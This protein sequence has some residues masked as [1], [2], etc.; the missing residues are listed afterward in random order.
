MLIT[1]TFAGTF[2]IC[3]M[4]KKIIRLIYRFIKFPETLYNIHEKLWLIERELHDLRAHARVSYM[5]RHNFDPRK[6]LEYNFEFSKEKRSDINFLLP[7]LYDYARQ[8]KHITEMGS[9]M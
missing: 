6:E 1:F 9:G 3:S 5:A 7:L 8:C 2:E 4:L